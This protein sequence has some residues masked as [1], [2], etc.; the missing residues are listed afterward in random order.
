MRRLFCLITV[1]VLS[2]FL[3]SCFTNYKVEYSYV[4]PTVKA[5]RR[6]VAKCVYARNFCE[7]ICKM[8][9]EN[10]RKRSALGDLSSSCNKSCNCVISFN[11]CYSAC[12][13]EVVEHKISLSD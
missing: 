6:C 3:V 9:Q 7:R 8:K 11:T 4:P 13:G 5:D 1:L 2:F 12:G 10:C